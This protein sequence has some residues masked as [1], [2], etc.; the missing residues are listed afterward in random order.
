MRELDTSPVSAR[1]RIAIVGWGG[2]LVIPYIEYSR[3][4][5]KWF[6]RCIRG[7]VYRYS[8]SLWHWWEIVV[9]HEERMNTVFGTAIA[10]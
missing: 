7:G 4:S 1:V 6:P 10:F 3:Y 9:Y 2:V 5:L 8:H